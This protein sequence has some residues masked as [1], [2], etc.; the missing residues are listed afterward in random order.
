MMTRKMINE[1]MRYRILQFVAHSLICAVLSAWPTSV[2]EAADKPNIV[3]FL[4]DDQGY[5]DLGCFGSESLETP[6]STGF[7]NRG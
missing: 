4:T 3:V 6:T 2:V 1:P 7:A 5:G